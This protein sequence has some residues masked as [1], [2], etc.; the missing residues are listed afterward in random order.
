MLRVYREGAD[1]YTLDFPCQVAIEKPEYLELV[2]E[3]LGC[4]EVTYVGSN[5][6][7]CVAGVDSD[8]FVRG[9]RPNLSLISTLPERGFLLS[10]QDSS[11]KFDYIYR[12]FFP[13]LGV[14]E[15]PVTG[16]ANTLLGPYWGE[17]TGKR[18]IIK[19]DAT[20]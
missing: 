5:G 3:I 19:W 18:V 12:G 10:A 14:P 2:K 6:E 4:D 11:G 7:D 1:R 17:V 20:L 13:K 16:S 9:C 8:D 15:D